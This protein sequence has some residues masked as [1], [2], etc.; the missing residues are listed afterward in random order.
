VSISDNRNTRERKTTYEDSIS[1][2]NATTLLTEHDMWRGMNG[3]G[4]L[5]PIDDLKKS[6]NNAVKRV[7]GNGGMFARVLDLMK[8]DGRLR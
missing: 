1:D 4:W 8:G 6:G 7:N 3:R 5:G 2:T